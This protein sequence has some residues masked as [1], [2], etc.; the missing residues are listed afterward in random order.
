MLRKLSASIMA[1]SLAFL[2]SPLPAWSDDGVVA[3]AASDPVA[4]SDP[5]AGVEQAQ[6]I[7]QVVVAWEANQL[8]IETMRASQP[9]EML[10]APMVQNPGMVPPE[11]VIEPPSDETSEPSDEEQEPPTVETQ[12]PPPQA[13]MQDPPPAQPRLTFR[14]IAE[15]AVIRRLIR[16]YITEGIQTAVGTVITETDEALKA[17]LEWLRGISGGDAQ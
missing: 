5:G 6:A 7:E 13:G 17:F 10:S 1:I 14:Q 4:A 15:R 16:K 11:E 2:G 12:D 3:P 9:A 8:V